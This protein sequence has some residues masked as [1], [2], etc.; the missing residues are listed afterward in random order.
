MEMIC[1]QQEWHL[2]TLHPIN[3]TTQTNKQTNWLPCVT[4]TQPYQDPFHNS[5]FTCYV[6][7]T[8]FITKDKSF[9]VSSLC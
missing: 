7:A 4:G 2:G 1:L 8:M 9:L 5:W 6:I 3:T